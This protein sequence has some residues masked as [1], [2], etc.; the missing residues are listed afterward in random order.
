MEYQTDDVDFCTSWLLGLQSERFIARCPRWAAEHQTSDPYFQVS[1]VLG[2]V[3]RP[4]NASKPDAKPQL[5][6]WAKQFE[7]SDPEFL[8]SRLLG[9]IP[10]PATSK[11]GRRRRK[12]GNE[13]K[14]VAQEQTA[15][16][17]DENE[18][19]NEEDEGL[20][21]SDD[22]GTAKLFGEEPYEV[23]E[24]DSE[25]DD[26]AQKEGSGEKASE[27]APVLAT[28]DFLAMCQN[29]EEMLTDIE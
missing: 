21:Q 13:D 20:D 9:L 11:R 26:E 16:S 19:E 15:G 25:G 27:E 5:P 10:Y 29:L 4:Y 18:D 12:D 17:N 2:L 7:S 28:P 6:E 1:Y 3:P 24:E 8:V 23:D 14:S 22:F